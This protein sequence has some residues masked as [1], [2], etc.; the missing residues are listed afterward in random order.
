MRQQLVGNKLS[1]SL[2]STSST[3][4]GVHRLVACLRLMAALPADDGEAVLGV[5]MADGTFDDLR[6]QLVTQLKK[7]VRCLCCALVL[8]VHREILYGLGILRLCSVPVVTG[9]KGIISGPV[10]GRHRSQSRS[11]A[12]SRAACA[13]GS[14]A[15]VCRRRCGGEPRAALLEGRRVKE[16]AL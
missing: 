9:C 5:I 2:R 13:A 15:E 14:A 11:S 4:H 10:T 8:V 7:D 12:K 16:G 1:V 6:Q 3:A